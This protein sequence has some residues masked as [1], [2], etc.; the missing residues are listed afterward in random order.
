MIAD[1]LARRIRRVDPQGVIRTVAGTGGRT[2][3]GDGGAATA[4]AIGSPTGV[5]ALPGGGYA[6]ASVRYAGYDR[7]QAA[8]RVVDSAGVITTRAR[9]YATAL[10]AEADGSLL[11]TDAFQ[12]NAPVRRL[13]PDGRVSVA[14]AVGDRIG[15]PEFLHVDG[16]P[17]GSDAVT[18]SA[19]VP[20]PDGGLLL[21]AD[22][23]I[24]YVA[25]PSPQVLAVALLPATRR[26][27]RN[28]DVSVRLTRGAHVTVEARREGR[29][30][31]RASLD[32]SAG[33]AVISLGRLRPG[34][35]SVRVVTEAE[36]QVATAHAFV[37]AGGRLP[38]TFVRDFLA[39]R[40]GLSETFVGGAPTLGR[41][42]QL[43][44]RRVDC[45]LRRRR[46]CVE[47][48]SVR[49]R[50]DGTLAARSRRCPS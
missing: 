33:D 1:F 27:R 50:L 10:A 15:I 11:L 43:G 9:Q 28:L 31:A 24:S 18:T 14:V 7:V 16:D 20:A 13:S 44:S 26:V 48:I 8:I 39:D 35:Y 40:L 21:A 34:L 17:F 46:R 6:I 41:C 45:K 38:V 25:A 4:A 2:I 36:G 30:R 12:D 42:A 3:S 49:Q 5:A 22:F 37:L 19:A 47:V 23:G 29:V 32:A